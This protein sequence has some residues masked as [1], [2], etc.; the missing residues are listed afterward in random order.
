MKMYLNRI[1]KYVKTARER[2]SRT[3]GAKYVQEKYFHQPVRTEHP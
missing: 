1:N 3:E 2:E